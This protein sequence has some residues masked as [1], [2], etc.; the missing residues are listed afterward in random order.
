MAK[1]LPCHTSLVRRRVLKHAGA[2][3]LSC[4]M[5]GCRPGPSEQASQTENKNFTDGALRIDLLH[6]RANGRERFEL[7]RLRVEPKWPGPKKRFVSALGWGDYRLSV[8]EPAAETLLFQQGFDSNLDPEARSA[9]TRLSIRVPLP[10]R[11]VR[12]VIERRRA[13]SVFQRASD[14]T[15]DPAAPDIERGTVKIATRVETVFSNGEPHAKV[16][17][18]IL[19]DGYRETEYGKFTADAQRAVS[20]LFSVDPFKKRMRDFNVYSVFAAS[21]ESGV[22][23]PYV[24]VRKDTVLRC[25]YSSGEAERTLAVGDVY[26]L[27][28]T[29]STVPYDFLLVLANARRY[30][31][32]AFFGGP[33]VVAIDSAAARYLVLHEF[34]HVIGGLAEEYYIPTSHGPTFVGNVEPW[35]PNVTIS[36]GNA[37]WHQR[38]AEPAKAPSAWNKAEYEKYFAGYV[39]R[40]FALRNGR[41][42]EAIVEKF[43]HEEM[44]RQAALLAKIGDSRKVGFFEGANGYARGAFR[45]EV[46]CIMFSLQTDYF[47][48]ACSSAIE[49]MIDEHCL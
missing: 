31:G 17:L 4:F 33:A 22:T 14:V 10:R 30:G 34:G 21:L 38:L 29:A 8:Y 46:N 20:Y 47:C 19:G 12:A 7:T 2:V 13:E 1:D 39:K 5:P 40:Y 32:S 26:A 42:D 35:H 37:K 28:E 15:L 9:A 18:A 48:A 16:D 44:K 27:H 6:Q 3:G 36:L 41:A 43:I 25:A 45:A 11:S 23:D 49:R 24:G